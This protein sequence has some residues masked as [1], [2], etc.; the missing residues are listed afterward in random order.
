MITTLVC[1]LVSAA[2]TPRFVRVTKTITPRFVRQLKLKMASTTR[3]RYIQA[4]ILLP[5]SVWL[6]L[7]LKPRLSPLKNGESLGL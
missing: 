3:N 5:A 4:A 7:L 6:H 2:I 1:V